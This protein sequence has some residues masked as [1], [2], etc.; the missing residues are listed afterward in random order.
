[1]T[2]AEL[3]ATWPAVPQDLCERLAWLLDAPVAEERAA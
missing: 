2:A 3:V 1:M